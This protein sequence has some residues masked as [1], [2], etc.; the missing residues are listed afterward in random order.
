MTTNELSPEKGLQSKYLQYPLICWLGDLEK[1]GQI[2]NMDGNQY[3]VY[4]LTTFLTGC[5]QVCHET[6]EKHLEVQVENVSCQLSVAICKETST[7]LAGWEWKGSWLG[8]TVAS[9]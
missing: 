4:N 7:L 8:H 1:C 5:D 2:S 9:E 3:S 6:L